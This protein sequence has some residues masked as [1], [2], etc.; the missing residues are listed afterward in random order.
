MIPAITFKRCLEAASAYRRGPTQKGAS[1][2]TKLFERAIIAVGDV[3][4]PETRETIVGVSIAVPPDGMAASKSN[5]KSSRVWRTF[6][7]IK[8]WSGK[9]TFTC[10]T[11]D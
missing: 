5:Q 8:E 11:T 3:I 6:P 9:I 10:S 7:T 1:T 4:L 2:Y